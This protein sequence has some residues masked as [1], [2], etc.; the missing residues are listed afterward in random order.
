M[1]RKKAK[2]E[3]APQTRSSK[4]YDPF[5]EKTLCEVF[6]PEWLRET[7][8]ETGL[9]KRERKIDPVIMFWVLT[10]SFGVRLQRTLASLKRSYTGRS[11]QK[12]S[13][14]SWYE[15][16]TPELVL[17]MKTCVMHGIEHFARDEKR[18]LSD[19]LN[20]FKDVLIQDSSVIRL[21]EALADKFPATRARKVAAGV[22]VSLVVSA[23]ADGPKSVAFHGERTS[24]INTLRIG[25]WV[26][27]RIL[28]I[29]LGF[30]KHHMFTKIMENGGYF[31]S[32]LKGTANPLIISTNRT[33]RG[34]SIDIIGKNINEVLP[35]LRRQVLDVMVEVP[36]KRRGYRGKQRGDT[37][38][39]RLV[40][41]YNEEEKKYHAYIT[42]ID[43]DTL[44]PDE[45]ASL[46]G[47]RWEI[48]LIFKELK[49]KYALDLVKT[50]NPQIVEA[51]IWTAI[52]TLLVSKNVHS[53]VRRRGEKAGKKA[54]RFTQLRWSNTFSENNTKLLDAIFAH[55]DIEFNLMTIHEVYDSDALDPHVNRKRFREEWWS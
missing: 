16:F 5:I 26:K 49:S 10:L 43:C 11:G 1:T 27:D 13:D 36:I 18:K 25:S 32:R 9:V 35:K 53:L 47:A 15:R 24:E 8:K 4:R 6:P 51:Y 34:N 48:E 29:D 19:R 38:V 31:V 23:V 55:L 50:K 21:H 39:F 54:V 41:I 46:Y 17:F 14:G 7:A 3:T 33:C 12:V 28:L 40:A 52:L 22:K 30:Y 20:I 45:V 44:G 37:S 42:N 2:K